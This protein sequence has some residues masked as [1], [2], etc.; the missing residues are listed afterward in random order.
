MAEEME[1]FLTGEV[2]Q[3]SRTVMQLSSLSPFTM[4]S[5]GGFLHYECPND[6][7]VDTVNHKNISQNSA[8][9]FC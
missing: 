6:I 8:K 1:F 7:N 3:Y 9:L 5:F 2:E 4:Y